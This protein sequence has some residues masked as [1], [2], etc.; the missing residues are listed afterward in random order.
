MAQK[1]PK[2]TPQQ[3]Q[4]IGHMHAEQNKPEFGPNHPGMVFFFDLARSV[5]NVHEACTGVLATKMIHLCAKKKIYYV[6]KI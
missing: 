3:V 1:R 4:G 5:Q 6:E 2:R